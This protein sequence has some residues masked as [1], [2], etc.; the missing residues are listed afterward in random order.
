MCFACLS[1]I[2]NLIKGAGICLTP[3]INRVS[4]GKETFEHMT[5]MIFSV[6]EEG[7]GIIMVHQRNDVPCTG[8]S[9]DIFFPFGK[10]WQQQGISQARVSCSPLVEMV[11]FY[12]RS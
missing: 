9:I 6:L 4:L 10:L 8:A 7:F 1:K 11:R 5:I 2:I 3:S 12:T